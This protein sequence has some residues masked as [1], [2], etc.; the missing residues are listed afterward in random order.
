[1]EYSNVLNKRG[2]GPKASSL[3]MILPTAYSRVS[4]VSGESGVPEVEA[5][6]ARGLV[7]SRHE[8]ATHDDAMLA[9]VAGRGEVIIEGVH[10]VAA[11]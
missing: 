11:W 6:K 3:V 9:I 1:M 7:T 5:G 10:A 8:A 4:G 2:E